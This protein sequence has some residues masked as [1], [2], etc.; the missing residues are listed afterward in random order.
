MIDLFPNTY[1]KFTCPK[2][3]STKVN[4]GDFY[5]QGIHTLADCV[6]G[7][8]NYEFITDFPIS[9]A[10]YHPISI[11][12]KDFQL[13]DEHKV[14]WFSQPLLDSFKH[15]NNSD[16]V[17]EKKIFNQKKEVILLNC[18]DNLYG[19]VILKLF[20]STAYLKQFP[21]Y[22]LIILLPKS[23]EWLLPTGIS[24]AWL[25]D[26]KL[27]ETK[28]WY[29]KL[30]EFV[31]TEIKRFTKVHLSLAFSHPDF[32]KINIED[33][34]KVNKFNVKT[35]L[36]NTPQLT[37]VWREDRFW[38][39]NIFSSFLFDLAEN[40]SEL[41]FFKK[42]LT[43]RQKNKVNKLYEELKK[44]IPNI[45]FN[46]VGVGKSFK[47][48]D[49]INDCRQTKIDK[50]TEMKWCKIYSESHIV[51]GVHGSNMIL[52]TALSAGFI[53][54]LPQKRFGNIL[55]DIAS[56]KSG[57]IGMFLSRFVDDKISPK[58]LA[59]LAASMFLVFPFIELT[60]SE[61]YLQHKNYDDVTMWQKYYRDK[62]ININAKKI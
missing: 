18:L 2:C 61:K 29:L 3:S 10:L 44:E 13:F 21:E 28:N 41:S 40:I 31:K 60:M 14:K 6:C 24:E 48:Q 49:G 38:L 59:K 55:E 35:Y 39:T 23:F 42:W 22:G 46:V 51:I 47:F 53:E 43:L 33:Y 17:I 19:H 56:D 52:P 1:S 11:G 30:D 57:R 34:T 32:S 45:I 26:I 8:C 5:F 54:L 4:V 50:D 7:S 12:K 20:N 37:F 58:S 16:L 62:V 36:D 25:V 9:H 15:K 27:S